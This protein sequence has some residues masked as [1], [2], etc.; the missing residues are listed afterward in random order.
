MTQ[1][2]LRYEKVVL[3]K[4]GVLEGIHREKSCTKSTVVL[5]AGC[6]SKSLDTRGV[7]QRASVW[8]LVA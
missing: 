8:A 6:P 3:S 1:Q 2:L 5:V 7:D 4:C